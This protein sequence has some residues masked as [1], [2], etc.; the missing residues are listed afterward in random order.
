M[1]FLITKKIKE[2]CLAAYAHMLAALQYI[3]I[4]IAFFSMTSTLELEK[5]T[6]IQARSLYTLYLQQYMLFSS[7]QSPEQFKTVFLGTLGLCRSCNIMLLAF[8]LDLAWDWPSI[9]FTTGITDIPLICSIILFLIFAAKTGIRLL[10]HIKDS[11]IK[12]I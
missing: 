3:D 9:T 7:I 8:H 10:S 12:F 5:S 4:D 2:Y 6:D 11:S 1:F